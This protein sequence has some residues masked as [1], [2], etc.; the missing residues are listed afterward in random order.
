MYFPHSGFTLVSCDPRK[1]FS[2]RGV[3]KL[4]SHCHH[5]LKSFLPNCLPYDTWLSK[6]VP[7]GFYSNPTYN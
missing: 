7:V 5:Q 6:P 3:R 4:L 2:W 1:T